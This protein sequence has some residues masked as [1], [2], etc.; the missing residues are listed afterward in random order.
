ML[1]VSTNYT[2]DTV[3]CWVNWITSVCLM[4]LV[5]VGGSGRPL[6]GGNLTQG[7]LLLFVKSLVIFSPLGRKESHI[8]TPFLKKTQDFVRYAL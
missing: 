1:L 3:Y 4:G 7:M 8:D 6:E 5:F 2:L